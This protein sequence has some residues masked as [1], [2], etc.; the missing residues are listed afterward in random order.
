[1]K[2]DKGPAEVL[3]ALKSGDKEQLAEALVF[4]RE[5]FKAEYGMYPEEMIRQMEPSLEDYDYET[6]GLGGT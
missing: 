5:S 4:Q 3:R 1:M 2:L 6:E